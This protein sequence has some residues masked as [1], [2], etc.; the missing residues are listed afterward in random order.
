MANVTDMKPCMLHVT[1]VPLAKNASDVLRGTSHV[2][3]K[4]SQNAMNRLHTVMYAI[5]SVVRGTFCHLCPIIS[6][7]I[8]MD[9]MS[10]NVPPTFGI[11][12]IALS[13]EDAVVMIAPSIII[14]QWPQLT[15]HRS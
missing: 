15:T 11:I 6:R 4:H 10:D 7:N 2:P 14:L 8:N 3:R 1:F 9:P 5:I 13:S 12:T